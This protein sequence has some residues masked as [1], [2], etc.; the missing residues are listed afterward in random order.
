[1]KA[2]EAVVRRAKGTSWYWVFSGQ[3]PLEYAHQHLTLEARS[4]REDAVLYVHF[5]GVQKNSSTFHSSLDYANKN[6]LF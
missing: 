2:L 1:M 3:R 5:S 4:E 6:H